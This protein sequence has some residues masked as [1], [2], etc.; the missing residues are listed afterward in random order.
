MGSDRD[1]MDHSFPPELRFSPLAKPWPEI[2]IDAGISSRPATKNR[3]ETLN[4]GFGASRKHDL[5]RDRSQPR[6]H[7]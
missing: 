4:S 6:Q 2:G 7:A 1:L 5:W 3:L